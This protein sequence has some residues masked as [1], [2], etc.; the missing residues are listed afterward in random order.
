MAGTLNPLAAF[1]TKPR[2]V[3]FQNQDQGEK[4]ILL[5]RQHVITNLPWVIISFALALLPIMFLAFQEGFAFWQ[6]LSDNFRWVLLALWYLISFGYVLVNFLTWYFSVMLVTNK[7]IMDIDLVG[8]L[9]RQVT[10][11]KLKEVQDVSHTQGGIAQIIFNYG[12]LYVQT[13][14][15]AQN[16][17]ILKVPRPGYVHDFITDLVEQYGNGNL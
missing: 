3:F 8:F 11:T 16:I 6:V 10:E 5:L 12:N 9:Y 2:R 17:E 4:I 13:A 15:T 1:A 14:G 7:R